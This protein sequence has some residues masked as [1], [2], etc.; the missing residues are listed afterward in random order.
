MIVLLET[1]LEV[2][3]QGEKILL[4][5]GSER[6]IESIKCIEEFPDGGGSVEEQV[7]ATYGR[8]KTKDQEKLSR[9]N[10]LQHCKSWI[11]LLHRKNKYKS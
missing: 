10:R 9:P 3:R 7:V 1:K 2:A 4:Q 8:K 5:M 11:L 6:I